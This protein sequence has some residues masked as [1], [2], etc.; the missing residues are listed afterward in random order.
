MEQNV[1]TYM[2]EQACR[3]RKTG[4]TSTADL[5]R[6][7][8]NRL[9]RFLCGRPLA[10]NEVTTMLVD[11]FACSLRNEGLAIN[12]VNSYLSSFRALYNAARTAGVFDGPDKHPFAHLRLR[13]EMTAKRA[14]TSQTINELARLQPSAGSTTRRALDFF[15]F[16]FMACGMPFIDLA[17]LTWDNIVGKEIVYHR[18]KTGTRVQVSITP[19][20]RLI[21]RRYARKGSRYLFPIL[22]E[23]GCSH[24]QYKALLADYNATLKVIG[25]YLKQPV[26]LTSYVARHSWATE[27]LRQ[28][29]PVAVISQAMGHT[30]EKTTRFYLAS[31][32]QAVM[33][34]ANRKITKMVNDLIV[35]WI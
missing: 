16:S 15:L 7:V 1:C 30:S 25:S 34:R 4:R 6:A 8:Q 10:F 3:I 31:L 28:N 35:G 22:P 27:A 17:H 33:S 32:D 14:L 23:E 11:D 29:T 13:R 2:A 9:Q 21:L 24:G 12:T 18:C 26:K 5:Y 19:A 20:M